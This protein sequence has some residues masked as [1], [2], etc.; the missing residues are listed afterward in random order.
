MSG[1]CHLFLSTANNP[2]EIDDSLNH[3]FSSPLL[4]HWLNSLTDKV[5]EPVCQHFRLADT[6]VYR[7]H[8]G[9]EERDGWLDD[10]TRKHLINTTEEMV[11]E[12][13]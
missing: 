12:V 11:E 4:L 9:S 2:S 5:M 8:P 1:K 3:T 10:K 7:E 13:I 6:W